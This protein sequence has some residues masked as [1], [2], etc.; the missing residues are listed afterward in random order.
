[1]ELTLDL[2]Y[3]SDLIP[4]IIQQKNSYDKSFRI[5]FA[6]LFEG[7]N[8]TRT[9]CDKIPIFGEKKRTIGH[10]VLHART[11]GDPWPTQYKLGRLNALN[12]GIR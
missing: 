2:I 1:M 8:D 5:N 11:R 7:Q 3:V 12:Y 9:A 6:S 4:I 10:I